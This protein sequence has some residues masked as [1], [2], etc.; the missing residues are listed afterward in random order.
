MGLLIDQGVHDPSNTGGFE[1]IE[2][3]KEIVQITKVELHKFIDNALNVELK[4]IGQNSKYNGRVVYDAVNFD[5]EHSMAF[6]YLQLRERCGVPYKKN[7]GSQVDVEAILMNKVVAVS[8]G[9]KPKKDSP[10][11]FYQTVRYLKGKAPAEAVAPKQET[12]FQ[13]DLDD[14]IEEKNQKERKAPTQQPDTAE[15]DW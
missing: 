7:E 13:D 1:V 8:L 14:V 5:P 15:V 4:I 10:G 9:K 11:E 6:R 3:A 2:S 12:T